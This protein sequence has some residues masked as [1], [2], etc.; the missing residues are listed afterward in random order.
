MPKC[1]IDL[2]Y[3]FGVCSK[4]FDNY[5]SG[6][7]CDEQIIQNICEVRSAVWGANK[8]D[9]LCVFKDMGVNCV[10]VGVDDSLQLSMNEERADLFHN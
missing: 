3:H 8:N 1:M 5:S 10:I 6:E 2:H 4:L 9:P 7:C